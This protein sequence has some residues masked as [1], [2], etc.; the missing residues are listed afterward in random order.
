MQ[1]TAY[2]PGLDGAIAESA[3]LIPEQIDLMLKLGNDSET[4]LGGANG[5]KL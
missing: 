1:P 4:W 5:V 3:V 2:L